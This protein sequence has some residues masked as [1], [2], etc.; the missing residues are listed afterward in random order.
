MNIS[1]QQSNHNLDDIDQTYNTL[2]RLCSFDELKNKILAAN[3]GSS[4]TFSRTYNDNNWKIFADDEHIVISNN[5]LV[6]DFNK[7]LTKYFNDKK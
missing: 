2:K 3:P 1:C 6:E 7:E 5:W 4:Y